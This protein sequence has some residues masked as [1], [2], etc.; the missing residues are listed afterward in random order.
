MDNLDLNTGTFKKPYFETDLGLAFAGD[1]FQAQS[2]VNAFLHAASQLV[3]DGE[4]RPV[5]SATGL[6][7]LLKEVSRNW[8]AT[9]K[10]AAP[11]VQFLLFGYSPKS[12]L[13]WA[14]RIKWPQVTGPQGDQFE[15]P[16]R[17]TSVFIIGAEAR[18]EG[19]AY[20]A[21][22]R[23]MFMKKAGKLNLA[24]L[25]KAGF[26]PD[27]EVAKLFNADRM[28]IEDDVASLLIAH[29][30]TTIGGVMQKIE[31]IPTEGVR[32]TAAFSKDDAV[33][34][35]ALSDVELGLTYRSVF[36]SMGTKGRPRP[37]DEAFAS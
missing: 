28:L 12:A 32:C 1:C 20:A 6:V 13:P 34:L 18:P 36:S 4:S 5:P 26:E 16:L 35:D 25:R 2:I 23:N 30:H 31:I 14:G 8:L 27:L 29:A 37:F 9:Y 22:L 24:E 19:L 33:Y 15:E 3:V 11:D 10:Q 7:R 17:A 21:E